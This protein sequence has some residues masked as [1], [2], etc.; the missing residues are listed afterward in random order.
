MFAGCMHAFSI[1]SPFLQSFSEARGAAAPV[2]RLIDEVHQD[3]F[4]LI[5][6]LSI[7]SRDIGTNQKYK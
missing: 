2:F 4:F 7:Y 5:S 6:M 3:L 1:I